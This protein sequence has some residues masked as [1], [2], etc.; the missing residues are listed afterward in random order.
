MTPEAVIRRLREIADNCEVLHVIADA[1][2]LRAI[3]KWIEETQQ[4]ALERRGQQ[5]REAMGIWR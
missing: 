2:D 1:R 4:I 3:A 5:Q